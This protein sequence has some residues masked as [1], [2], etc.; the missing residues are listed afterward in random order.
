MSDQAT[1]VSPGTE[2]KEQELDS[3]LGTFTDAVRSGRSAPINGIFILMVF[4]T[5][6]FAAP[7]LIPITVAFLLSMLLSPFAD[8]LERLRLPRPVAAALI[9]LLVFG[10]LLTSLVTLAGPAQ[11]WIAKLPQSF[12]TVESQLKFI[13]KPLQDFKEATE[14]IESATDLSQRPPRQK[15]EIQRPGLLEDIFSGTQRFIASIGVIMILTFSLL[16]SGDLVLRKLVTVI[17]TLEDKRRAVEI[18]R[19]IQK[20]ISYY[21]SAITMLN[22]GMAFCVG[23]LAYLMGI[24]NAALWGA[25]VAVLAFMPYIGS[26]TIIIILTLVCLVEFGNFAEALILP[27]IFLAMSTA[28]QSVMVPFVLGRRLLLSPVAIFL[29]I[30]LWGWMWGIVGALLAVPLLASFKIICERFQA[31]RLISEFLTP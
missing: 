7:V 22:L 1:P 14:K 12:K 24:E 25:V 10:G 27:L 16:A 11:E 6:Y 28:V 29:A 5:I 21:L 9:M 26:V 8:R 15:V 4:Y 19:S 20:D 18:M 31:L 3:F 30:I 23:A 2:K 17:P 13:K